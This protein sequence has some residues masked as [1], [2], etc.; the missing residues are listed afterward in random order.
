MSERNNLFEIFCC[1]SFQNLI[2]HPPVIIQMDVAELDTIPDKVNQIE[3]IFGHIDILINNAGISI[4]ADVAS[5][6]VDVDQRVM[7]VNYFGSIAMTKGNIHLI[8]M[9]HDS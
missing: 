2:T 9:M 6:A 5:M 7:L 8:F 4:R 1:F 3:N